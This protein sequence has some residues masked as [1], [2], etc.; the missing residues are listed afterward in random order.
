MADERQQPGRDEETQPA[1]GAPNAEGPDWEAPAPSNGEVF[2]TPFDPEPA[3]SDAFPP[4][5]EFGSEAGAADGRP[6]A[7]AVP[8]KQ[9]PLSRVSRLTRPASH[10]GPRPPVARPE[11]PGGGH[12]HQ[13]RRRTVFSACPN[14]RP[15]ARERR[16]PDRH[17]KDSQSGDWRSREGGLYLAPADEDGNGSPGTGGSRIAHRSDRSRD[18]GGGRRAA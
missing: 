17:R 14:A 2:E 6:W 13:R 5:V 12:H 16:S 15:L 18:P 11:D 4:L 1:A 10:V 7:Q 3:R 9:R 8:P